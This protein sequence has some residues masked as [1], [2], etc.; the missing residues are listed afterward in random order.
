MKFKIIVLIILF[1]SVTLS[2]CGR[3]TAP[4]KPSQTIEKN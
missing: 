4:L 3:K 1:F 2:S